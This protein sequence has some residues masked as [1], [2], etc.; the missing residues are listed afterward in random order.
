M[1][2]L[3]SV[4]VQ[5]LREELAA[6]EQR[7]EEERTAHA[8]SRQVGPSLATPWTGALKPNA[9]PAQLHGAI[10]YLCLCIRETCSAHCCKQH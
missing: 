8:R 10:A 3:R 9:K 2:P 5:A 4:V 1:L 6:T 7:C